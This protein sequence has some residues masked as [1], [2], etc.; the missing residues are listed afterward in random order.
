MMFARPK[1]LKNPATSVTVVAKM[2]AD[3]AGAQ[4]KAVKVLLAAPERAVA[5]GKAARERMLSHYSWDARLAPL[6]GMLGLD[7]RRAAA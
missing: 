1:K 3:D 2:V 6:G 4:A 5:M 7:A